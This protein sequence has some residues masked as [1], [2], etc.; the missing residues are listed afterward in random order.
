MRTLS[1]TFVLTLAGAAALLAACSSSNPATPGTDGGGGSPGGFVGIPLTP[2]PATGFVTDTTGGSG[3]IGAW[4]AYGDSAG[5]GANSTGPD[6]M[7]SQCAIGGFT[8]D[9]CSQITSPMPGGIFPPM[10]N[11]MCTMGVAAQVLAGTNGMDD[12]TDLFGA[13]I[14]L[15][16][17][18]PGGDAGVKMPIDLSTYKGFSFDFSGTNIPA[19]KI[20]VN[21]PFVG[22]H[23]NDSP[24]FSNAVSDDH[25]TL[26][27]STTPGP[28]TVLW[29]DILGPYYLSQQTPA[30]PAPPFLPSMVE[31]IQFQ[32]FTNDKT[33]TPYAFCVNNLTLLTQ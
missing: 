26:V 19:G 27:G 21:F 8:M 33:S 20:R 13:G 16:L 14:G 17:N 15:D 18:N 11:G 25:S 2:D 3:I 10:A 32:V 29:K 24:Y 31:S 5:P 28:N 30:V 1:N 9:K 23:G 6:F 22:E 7:D 12:Y 4:Y